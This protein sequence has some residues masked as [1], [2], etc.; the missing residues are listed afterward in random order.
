VAREDCRGEGSGWGTIENVTL[1]PLLLVGPGRTR[2]AEATKAALELRH[3]PTLITAGGWFPGIA[4]A[5]AA[6]KT[7]PEL[8][9]AFGHEGAA[10]SAGKVAAGLG[11]PLLLTLEPED[12][13][14][15]ISRPLLHTLAFAKA[16]ILS[17]AALADR[18]RAQG[19]SRDL[20]V[21][22]APDEAAQH[23]AYFGALE[24]VYGRSLADADLEPDELPPVPEGLVQIGALK[25]SSPG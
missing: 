15:R 22:E 13:G 12:L 10:K 18:L 23:P 8:V 16:V 19:V 4:A 9:H 25:K 1:S 20:Y 14:E 21:I 5:S 6:Q 3:K 17:D 2:L 7:K 11:V 24:V